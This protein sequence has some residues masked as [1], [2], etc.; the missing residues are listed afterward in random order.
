MVGV[1]L[2]I[3]ALIDEVNPNG[4]N[5][6][7]LLRYWT[8]PHSNVVGWARGERIVASQL[9]LPAPWITGHE[10]IQA[11]TGGL[12]PDGRIPWVLLAVIAAGA[13]AWKRCD[14]SVFALAIVTLVFTIA[15]WISAARV[16]DEPFSY[17]LRWT[18]LV[19]ALAW[20]TIG[21]AAMRLLAEVYRSTRVTSALAVV[22]V[23][24][25]IALAV[26]T[27]TG[28]A[29]ADLPD[30]RIE[31]SL[32]AVEPALLSVAR[33]NP[34]PWLVEGAADINSGG[35]AAGVVALLERAGYA[36]GFNEDFAWGIGTN[37]VITPDRHPTVLLTAM[38]DKIDQ[39]RRDPQYQALRDEAWLTASHSCG[40]DSVPGDAAVQQES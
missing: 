20:L 12:L 35:L 11:F 31:Q 32:R 40:G 26:A 21:W 2:W 34:G 39:Y 38:D 30:P 29:R 33:Q 37:H 17:L 28:T 8:A 9:S 6:S 16:L 19:G 7:A 27:I 3:P 36:A 22:A 4:R 18:W 25:M 14:R 1:V 10:R 24:S 13:I 23:V 5:L 15:A